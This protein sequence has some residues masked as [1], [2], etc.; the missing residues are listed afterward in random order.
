MVYVIQLA[1]RIGTELQFRPDPAR[2]L[3][4]NLYDIPLLRVQWKTPDDGRKNCPKHVEFYSKNKFKKLVHLVGFIIRSC[5]DRAAF[6][7]KDRLTLAPP[8]Q[9][10]SLTAHRKPHHSETFTHPMPMFTKSAQQPAGSH[11]PSSHCLRYPNYTNRTHS[12]PQ[13]IWTGWK[14]C[15]IKRCVGQLAGA[16]ALHSPFLFSMNTG[17]FVNAGNLVVDCWWLRHTARKFSRLWHG[18]EIAAVTSY[19]GPSRSLKTSF[20][21]VMFLTVLIIVSIVLLLWTVHFSRTHFVYIEYVSC[22]FKFSH[23]SVFAVAD[24]RCFL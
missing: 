20:L 9:P 5:K 10:H 1:K 22:N 8:A 7:L 14:Q 19:K 17:R 3:S 12:A 13:Q 16:A 23:V 15:S 11:T 18:F 2:K 6:N 21:L 24:L 4:A